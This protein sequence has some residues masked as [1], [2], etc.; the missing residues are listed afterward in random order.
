MWILAF[1]DRE[2]M[3]GVVLVGLFLAT[4]LVIGIPQIIAEFR[5]KDEDKEEIPPNVVD[6]IFKDE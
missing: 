4:V 1:E 5:R 3:L 2:G 6:Q